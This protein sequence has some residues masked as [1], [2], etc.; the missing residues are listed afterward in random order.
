MQTDVYI[1]SL[2]WSHVQPSKL[3]FL[4]R[5]TGAEIRPTNRL[6]LTAR[7]A[8]PQTASAEMSF[9][10]GKNLPFWAS[11]KYFEIKQDPVSSFRIYVCVCVC[12]RANHALPQHRGF[13]NLL[14]PFSITG[15]SPSHARASPRTC[16]CCMRDIFYKLRLF[17]LA[18]WATPHQL[19]N[20]VD[21]TVDT[22]VPLITVRASC[23]LLLLFIF[24][25]DWNSFL[26]V[27][28]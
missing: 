11:L 24:G 3:I 8:G 2:N 1:S 16:T 9:T 13:W 4:P 6:T 7:L 26:H 27:F 17:I 21:L 10:L 15:Q 23:V 19:K 14:E 25:K 18:K 5:H 20:I 28:C 12:P 22:A